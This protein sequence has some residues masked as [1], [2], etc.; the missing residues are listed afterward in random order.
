MVTSGGNPVDAQGFYAYGRL[1][2][3]IIGVERSFTGQQ[4]D[5]GTGLIYFKCN[6]A[7]SG[8]IKRVVC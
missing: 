6:F 8:T 1:R 5:A 2:S 3:G 4:K 7:R